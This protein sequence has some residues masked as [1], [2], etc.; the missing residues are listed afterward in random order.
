MFFNHTAKA[1]QLDIRDKDNKLIRPG[2]L[3]RE[4]PPGS[5]IIARVTFHLW[6]MGNTLV[7]SLIAFD[8]LCSER[9]S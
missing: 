2:D 3:F 7:R 6:S 9:S 8:R 5:V 1:V 4:I